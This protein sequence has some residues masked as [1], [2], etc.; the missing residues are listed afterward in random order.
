METQSEFLQL[1]LSD[2]TLKTIA[3]KGFEIPTPIQKLAIPVLI[4]ETCD[5]IGQ[6]QTGTGKTAAFGLPI[7]EK[8]SKGKDGNVNALI[9][10]PTRELALQVTDEINSFKGNRDRKSTRLN[11]SHR[12]LTIRSRIDRK[13][14]RLNSS[15]RCF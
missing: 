10:V 1:G 8:I 2:E 9:L 15:H 3:E 14:T 4:H 5:I 11:S 13:S 6:A 12:C 7:I